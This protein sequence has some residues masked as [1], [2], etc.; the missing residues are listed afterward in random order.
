MKN[1]TVLT[2]LEIL[3][4]ILVFA[5]AAALCIRTFVYSNDLSKDDHIK[6]KAMN[7]AVNTAEL[8]KYSKGDIDYAL[9]ELNIDTVF[10]IGIPFNKNMEPIHKDMYDDDESLAP[11]YL[12]Y[13]DPSDEDDPYLGSAKI[14]FHDKDGNTIV[15]VTAS[16]QEDAK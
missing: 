7:Y 4:M 9:K 14:Y 12:L 13:I 11:A 2:L 15:S 8:L 5:L 1:K 6:A 3:L 10:E 16:W